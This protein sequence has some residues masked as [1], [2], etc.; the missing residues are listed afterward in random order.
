MGI[1]TQQYGEMEW[2]R[3]RPSIVAICG[4]HASPSVRINRPPEKGLPM[5][6]Q[7]SVPQLSTCMRRWPDVSHENQDDKGGHGLQLGLWSQEHG[8]LVWKSSHLPVVSHWFPQ[9]SVFSFVFRWHY[10]WTIPWFSVHYG[11]HNQSWLRIWFTSLERRKPGQNKLSWKHDCA[12][13]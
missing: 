13:C 1:W 8:L 6:T 4:P 2:G 12:A 5:R 9:T 7:A 11:I 10:C 3:R